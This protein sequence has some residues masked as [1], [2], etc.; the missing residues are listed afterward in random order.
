MFSPAAPVVVGAESKKK[1]KLLGRSEAR[2]NADMATTRGR[3]WKPRRNHE[4][5]CVLSAWSMALICPHK[6]PTGP[7][8]ECI[9]QCPPRM[10]T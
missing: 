1:R 8:V 7:K 6:S 5:V 10:G 2:R 3:C 9:P 4:I